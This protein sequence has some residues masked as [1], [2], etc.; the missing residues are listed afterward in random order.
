MW[1]CEKCKRCNKRRKDY[2]S[3]YILMEQTICFEKCKICDQEY[4]YLNEFNYCEKCEKCKRYN[5][6][7]RDY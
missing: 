7:R 6:Q 4:G 3:C 1:S 2:D 5:S